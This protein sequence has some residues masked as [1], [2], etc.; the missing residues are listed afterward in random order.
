MKT[1]LLLA[2]SAVA[3][4]AGSLQAQT[5]QTFHACYVPDVG[6]MYLIQLPGLPTQCL[7]SGHEEISWTEGGTGELPD[8]AVTT[9]KLAD[10]AVTAAKLGSDVSLGGELADGSV[11]TAILADQAVTSAKL[12]DGSVT[13]DRIAAGSVGSAQLADGSVG[14]ADL[15]DGSVTAAKIGSDVPLPPG[16]C[17]P[18]QI[19]SWNGSAW[20]CATDTG[21]SSVELVTTVHV[22]EKTA[23]TVI[24]ETYLSSCPVGKRVLGGG[25]EVRVD[26][27]SG[28]QDSWTSIPPVHVISSGPDGDT[29]WELRYWIDFSGSAKAYELTV[30][31]ICATVN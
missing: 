12:A 27:G 9:A 10:G 29:G 24:T 22:I 3:L 14:T 8:G 15:A 23:T 20:V 13:A 4:A 19:S 11:T 26:T 28:F 6:A 2:S 1:R 5:T 18:D 17:S 21:V 16:N 7:S 31:A 25:Y 30:E